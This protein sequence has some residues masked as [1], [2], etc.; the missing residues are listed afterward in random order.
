MPLLKIVDE[1][2]FNEDAMVRV[3]NYV[4]RSGYIGGLGVNPECAALQM[5]LVKHVWY[6]PEGRQ[7]RHFLPNSFH[8]SGK[9][10]QSCQTP[11]C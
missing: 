5:S 7:I 3:I 6:K 11:R 9:W 2:Y 10:E 4:C 1:S 8:G